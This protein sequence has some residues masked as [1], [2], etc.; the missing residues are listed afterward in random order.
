MKPKLS[1]LLTRNQVFSKLL[2]PMLSITVLNYLIA[3]YYNSKKFFPYQSVPFIECINSQQ[4]LFKLIVNWYIY[5][6][7]VMTQKCIMQLL[8]HFVWACL[9][10]MSL[11]MDFFFRKIKYH[12]EMHSFSGNGLMIIFKDSLWI[13][14]SSCQAAKAPLHELS[15]QTQSMSRTAENNFIP[16]SLKSME[17]ISAG[18]C[19]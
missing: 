17:K 15:D 9:Y 10:Y 1:A 3:I 6:M 5:N 18:F 16:S 4:V 7:Y 8:N 12:E 14:K 13:F 19:N 2:E 11:Q